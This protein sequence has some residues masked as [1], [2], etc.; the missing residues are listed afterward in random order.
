MVNIFDDRLFTPEEQ[1]ELV[2][3]A[4]SCLEQIEHL[5]YKL[6]QLAQQSAEDSTR[7]EERR[8]LQEQVAQLEQEIAEIAEMTPPVFPDR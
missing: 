7:D 1:L 6:E 8:R 4:D 3:Y 5:L 2:R